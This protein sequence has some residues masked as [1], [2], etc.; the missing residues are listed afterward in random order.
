MTEICTAKLTTLNSREAWGTIVEQF[1]IQ[2]GLYK[3]SEAKSREGEYNDALSSWL[4]WVTIHLKTLPVEYVDK[5][6]WLLLARI[7]VGQRCSHGARNALAWARAAADAEQ[8]PRGTGQELQK[9]M[10]EEWKKK[11]NEVFH[12]LKERKG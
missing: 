10:K 7:Y 3:S 5:N 8:T 2:N 1:G 12:N 9:F 6:Q 4:K 11:Y